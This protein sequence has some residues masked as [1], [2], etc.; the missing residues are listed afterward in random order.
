MFFPSKTA[1]KKLFKEFYGEI[2]ID[3][4]SVNFVEARATGT[5]AGDPQEAWAIDEVFCHNRKTALP[6]GTIKSNCGHAEAAAAMSSLAKVILT[7]ENRKIPPNLNFKTPRPEI[8]SLVEGR[9]RVVTEIEKLEGS[10]VA[11]NSFG[12]IGANSL[13]LLEGNLKEKINGGIP[14]DNLS[15]L[16]LWSGRTLEAADCVLNDITKRP[17]DVEHIVLLQNS[18]VKTSIAYIHRGFGIFKHDCEVNRAVCINK[19]MQESSSLKRPVAFIYSGV[20]TQ[21]LGMGCDLMEIPIFAEAIEQCH[22]ILASKDVNL[23]KILMSTDEKMFDENI[24]DDSL[25]WHCCSSNWFDEHSQSFEH[26]TRL[27]CRSLNWRIEL[28]IR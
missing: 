1:Q 10:L 15:S 11:M 20:G 25:N 2:N 27:Y 17:L 12:I 28:R 3:P 24:Y 18:Q 7:L 16:G 14:R 8:T 9:L 21:W 26:R 23:K 6:I 19:N 13:A 5:V 4:S 22:E